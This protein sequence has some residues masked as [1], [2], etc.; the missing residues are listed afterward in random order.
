MVAVP[1]VRRARCFLVYAR[2]PQDLGPA[3]ANRL[4]N[5]YVA[6]PARGLAL[7]HDHFIGAPGGVAVLYAA[8]EAERSAL[9][10]PG[11]LAGWTLQVHPLIFA[12]SPAALDE[13]IA[14]T[15]RAYRG[16]DWDALRREQR[17][18]Y[19]SAAAEART[20]AEEPD[21]A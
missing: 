21:Q 16:G 19:G 20:A 5:E 17:P 15:V 6:D 4:F 8:T 1:R 12:Y 7:F 9:A 14:Y 10:D 2:A 13:Q 18:R 3:Q 11:Q